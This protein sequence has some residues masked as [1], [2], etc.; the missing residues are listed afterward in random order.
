MEGPTIM[1]STYTCRSLYGILTCTCSATY[2]SVVTI[3]TPTQIIIFKN[4]IFKNPHAFPEIHSRICFV[5]LE[6]TFYG[7]NSKQMSTKMFEK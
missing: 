7:Y 4:F 2:H 1:D 3:T 5:C 6:E